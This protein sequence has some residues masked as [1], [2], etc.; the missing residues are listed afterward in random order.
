MLKKYIQSAMHRATYE[1][2]GDGTFYA[3]IPGLDGLWANGS[4]LEACRDELHSV[5]EGWIIIK[6][7]FG[8]D[9]PIIN[10]INL[11]PP[12]VPVEDEEEAI[13]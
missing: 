11:T 5:L 13:A 6:L 1:Q 9:L 8:D 3:E 4:T 7:R 2:L 12:L 10:D